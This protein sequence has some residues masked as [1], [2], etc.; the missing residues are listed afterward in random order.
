VSEFGSSVD[1]DSE[2]WADRSLRDYSH[3]GG[4]ERSGGDFE[5]EGGVDC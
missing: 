1:G 3:L 5:V 2:R 4:T